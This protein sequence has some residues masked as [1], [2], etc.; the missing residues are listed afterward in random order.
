MRFSR[1]QAASS[2]GSISEG[3][4]RT[5]VLEP[6]S[7]LTLPPGNSRTASPLEAARMLAAASSSTVV[8]YDPDVAWSRRFV[9][10]L[11]VE[12]RPAVIAV[13]H[14]PDSMIAD[15]WIRPGT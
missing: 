9:E 8:L 10:A 13:S 3:R 4:V 11:P 6:V 1:S 2:S 14:V 12:R 5:L 15:E 7:Q